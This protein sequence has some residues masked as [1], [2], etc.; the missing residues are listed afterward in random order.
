MQLH[1]LFVLIGLAVSAQ[2]L[3]EAMLRN[4][5]FPANATYVAI[6]SVPSENQQC[7]PDIIKASEVCVKAGIWL[8]YIDP[9][10]LSNT[11][12]NATMIYTRNPSDPAM[13]CYPLPPTL[14]KKVGSFRLAGDPEDETRPGLN[15]Y[16]GLWYTADDLFT[17]S[18]MSAVPYAFNSAIVT[19]TSAQRWQFFM[20]EGFDGFS[21][22][23]NVGENYIP[24]FTQRF[25]V[26]PGDIKSIR[27]D[28][29]KSAGKL[30]PNHV[31][32]G[33]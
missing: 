4:I 23:T 10:F 22:C 28:C 27:T 2:A 13:T 6:T 31:F 29:S 24:N 7:L 32:T 18:S 33:Y 8:F 25:G 21:E 17:N 16:V 14:D 15:L 5:K 30:N 9:N 11:L 20:K 1:L 12:P 3:P 19:G 26:Q